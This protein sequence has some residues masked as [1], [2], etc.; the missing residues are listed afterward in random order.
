ME[1]KIRTPNE[2]RKEIL[3]LTGSSDRRIFGEPI[4]TEVG[5]L[6]TEMALACRYL[7]GQTWAGA[8]ELSMA[9]LEVSPDYRAAIEFATAVLRGE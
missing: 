3:E 9:E 8:L 7:A 1:G 5:D 6:L 2:I 4:S